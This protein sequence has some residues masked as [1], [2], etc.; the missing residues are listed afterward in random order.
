[1]ERDCG[2]W[3][4]ILSHKVKRRLDAKLVNLGVNALQS[5]VL[6]Y[7]RVHY[8]DGPV[9]QRDVED[10]F[11]L[12]R[13]TATGVL[14]HLERSEFIRREAVQEDGR[15]KSLVPTE[16]AEELDQQIHSFLHQIEEEMTAGLSPGQLQMFMET[17]S[18]MS[19]N[20]GECG[21]APAEPVK[22][23]EGGFL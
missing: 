17:V 9:F 8:R 14:Q 12:S 22:T 4:N 5:R 1:M 18:R 3:V 2:M 13:S 11:G 7:I 23:R 21:S 19:S 6:H 15:L 10:A 20:L 16:R